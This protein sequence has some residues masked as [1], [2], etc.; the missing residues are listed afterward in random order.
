[1]RRGDAKRSSS[2]EKMQGLDETPPP[3]HCSALKFS[4]KASPSYFSWST[5]N[6]RILRVSCLEEKVCEEKII[7]HSSAER[8]VRKAG[9]DT[10]RDQETERPRLPALL[11]VIKQG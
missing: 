6:S 5:S 7:V 9:G 11:D 2:S 3:S 10:E 4:D 8:E 1:M